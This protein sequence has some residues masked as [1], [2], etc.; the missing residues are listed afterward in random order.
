VNTWIKF[1]LLGVVGLPILLTSAFP[2]SAQGKV[3]V[4]WSVASAAMGGMWVA[5][6]EGIFKKNGLDVELQHISSTSRTIPAM[7]AGEIDFSSV[8]VRNALQANLKG[9][10]LILVL[11]NA[12][13]LVL[14]LWARPEIKKVSDLRGKR[15]GI[16]RLGSAA[17]TA[18]VYALQKGGLKPGDYQLLSLV[19]MPSILT[20]LIAGQTDAGV[21]S[22]PVSSRAR[23]AGFTE[24]VNL[25]R[26]GP[27][28]PAIGIATTLRYINA[29]EEATRR[30][31][32]SYVEAVHLF[33][34]NKEIGKRAIQKYTKLND[35]DALDDSYLQA[36]EFLENIPY[37]SR[38]GLATLLAEL[39]EAEPKAKTA[40]P[41]D[42]LEMRFV[43]E[44]EREG[45]FKKLWGQR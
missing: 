36:R 33:K 38:A 13:R 39:A 2:S 11:G 8:D 32:R 40:K 18:A 19:E 45:F 12:N 34:T 21:F 4:N 24:L 10:D 43:S 16:T 26:D 42:F 27:E 15:I 6:E 1:S 7:L 23:Q 37:V 28:Y 14:S 17:H 25:Y 30:F 41:D 31:I 20:A 29:N 3:R 35:P 9:A 22:A 5:Y 44:L